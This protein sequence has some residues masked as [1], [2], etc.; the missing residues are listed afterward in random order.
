M[1]LEN[2]NDSSSSSSSMENNKRLKIKIIP[3]S[4]DLTPDEVFAFQLLLKFANPSSTPYDI[5]EIKTT[6]TTTSPSPDHKC[7]KCGKVFRSH[8]ALGGHQTT[9]RPK[10][11]NILHRCSICNKVFPSGH[12][13]NHYDDHQGFIDTDQHSSDISNHLTTSNN[14]HVASMVV[15]PN[16]DLNFPPTPEFC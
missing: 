1:A 6:T 8:Q 2:L 13:R 12:K 11:I 10:N 5:H 16:I 14:H 3:P 4:P 9:H 15:R 7:K